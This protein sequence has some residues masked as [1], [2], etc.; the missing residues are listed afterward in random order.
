M[1]NVDWALDD[2]LVNVMDWPFDNFMNWNWNWS[3]TVN[4][5]VDG[6]GPFDFMDLRDRDWSIDH[7]SVDHWDGPIHWDATFHDIAL[8]NRVWVNSLKDLSHRH[9]LFHQLCGSWNRNWFFHWNI[10]SNRNFNMIWNWFVDNG[11]THNGAGNIDRNFDAYWV[12]SWTLDNLFDIHWIRY[13]SFHCFNN[14]VWDRSINIVG[15]FNW[16]WAFNDLDDF[17]RYGPSDWIWRLNSNR[18]FH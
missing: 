9:S 10:L 4:R 12:W 16:N 1:M 6:V 15:S 11:F 13:T 3:V 17:H 7:F 18:L 2:L 14:L 8:M 5:A